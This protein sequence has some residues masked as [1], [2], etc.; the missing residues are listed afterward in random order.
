M[1]GEYPDVDTLSYFLVAFVTAVL[2][3]IFF[4]WLSRR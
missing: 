4:S 2:W 3:N 1:R